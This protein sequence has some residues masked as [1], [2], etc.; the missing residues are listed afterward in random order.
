[1]LNLVVDSSA[2]IGGFLPEEDNYFT[3]S[4]VIDEIGDESSK[5]RLLYFLNSGKILIKTPIEKTLKEVTKRSEIT[6]DT[7]SITDL[8][9]ISLALDLDSVIITEDYGIQNVASTLGIRC[10]SIRESG[11]KKTINWEYY[12]MGCKKIYSKNKKVCQDCGSKI[13]RRPRY[14]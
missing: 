6:G 1:M 5:E 8:K 2:I 10:K 7:L 11:I 3:V 14:T 4:E 9:L 12:C 13:K